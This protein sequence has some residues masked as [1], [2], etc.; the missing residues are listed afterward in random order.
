MLGTYSYNQVIRKCVVAF[1]TLFNNLEVRKLNKDGS[2]YQKMK[3]PLAYGPRQKFLSRIIEQPE[4]NK[5]VAIT[6]PRLS[7]EM[8]GIS[9]DASRK[10]S[11]LTL[12]RKADDSN[13]V[14]K[15]YT[16]VPYNIDFDLNIISKTN[17]EAL[18]IVEQ[19]LPNF[20]PA[21]TVS[22]KMVDAMDEYRDTPI[23]LNNISFTDDY[24]GSFDERKLVLFTLSFTVKTYVYG[25]TGASGVI[26]KAAVDYYTKVD[27][28][29]TRQVSYQVT[30]K[31]KLDYDKD[32]TLTLAQEITSKV[33]TFSV[34]DYS[35]VDI[36]DMIE[37]GNE[38]MKVI[39]KPETNK[40]TVQRAQNGTSANAVANGTPIDII[41]IADD[42]MVEFGDDFG[43]NELR[44][45]YG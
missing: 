8:T 25:P 12:T 41:T 33:L 6:L 16:P 18:E 17:D 29:A 1:G 22:I 15:Q 7:F 11:P 39:S 31:A 43:F 32:A 27:L 9:Y 38:V 36:G 30:P 24:E 37:V 19:I 44:S 34:S 26:K 13:A 45:F 21:Y 2:V 3:V 20:Q 5:T 14:K 10:L 28:Q 40:I 42:A 35:L 4:L 23:V